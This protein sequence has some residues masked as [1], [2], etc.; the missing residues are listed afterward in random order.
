DPFVA[1]DI[2][3]NSKGILI[4]EYTSNVEMLM[5]DEGLRGD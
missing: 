2:L 3:A 1:N 4:G 5:I